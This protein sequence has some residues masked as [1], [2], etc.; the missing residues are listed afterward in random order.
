[1]RTDFVRLPCVKSWCRMQKCIANRRLK[2][3]S[4]PNCNAI[5]KETITL[6]RINNA[7]EMSICFQFLQINIKLMTPS[8]KSKRGLNI[9]Y[10]HIV[11]QNRESKYLL[12]QYYRPLSFLNCDAEVMENVI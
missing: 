2:T 7:F 8:T 1:M 3:H 11:F 4:P 6:Y 5:S 12:I 10:P 9:I